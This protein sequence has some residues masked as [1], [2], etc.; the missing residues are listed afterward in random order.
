MT[1]LYFYLYHNA[2]TFGAIINYSR[3][4]V[5]ALK[6]KFKSQTHKNSMSLLQSFFLVIINGKQGTRD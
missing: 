1:S 4:S 5:V 6:L 2:Q 3:N